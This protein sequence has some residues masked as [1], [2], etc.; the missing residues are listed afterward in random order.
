MPKRTRKKGKS[1][2]RIVKL[3]LSL[4]LVLLIMVTCSY[5]INRYVEYNSYNTEYKEEIL[6]YSEIYGLNP[7]LVAAVIH[8]ES[9]NREDALSN[10]GAVGLMQIMPETGEWIAEK[11]GIENYSKE[12]LYDKD[13][14]I[15]MGC[16]YL[17]FL[18]ERFNGEF[19]NYV[20]AYNAGHGKVE[21]WLNNSDYSKDGVLVDIPYRE[22]RDYV[23]RVKNAM[24]KYEEI[25]EAIS[26]EKQ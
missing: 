22:T 10:K 17:K 9:S 13:I 16:W 3:F 26:S 5:L 4:I 15:E 7:V 8:C 12:L 14:N 18:Q 21:S 25:Y 23:K 2:K 6:K 20:A 11:I 24:E 19:V 1:V